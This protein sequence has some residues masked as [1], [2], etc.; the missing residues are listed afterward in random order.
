MVEPSGWKDRMVHLGEMICDLSMSVGRS[1]WLPGEMN[2]WD[3]GVVNEEEWQGS[4][5]WSQVRNN[6]R[7]SMGGGRQFRW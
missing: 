1:C 3:P 2:G 4:K 5:E 6:L 7:G